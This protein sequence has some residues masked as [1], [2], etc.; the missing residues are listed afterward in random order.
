M[1][2]SG[3]VDTIVD[4]DP[5]LVFDQPLRT[6]STGTQSKIINPE[7]SGNQTASNVAELLD[8]SGLLFIKTSGP[9]GL[10]TTSIRGASASQ[11]LV[12]WNGLPIQSPMLGQ[13]DFS[14]LP[15]SFVDVISITPGGAASSWGSGAVAGAILLE[16]KVTSYNS[17]E[18]SYAVG[19][20]SQHEHHLK[21]NLGG[22]KL[23]SETR[24][25]FHSSE[26]DF[27]FQPFRRAPRIR[28]EHAHFKQKG[29]LQSFS[30]SMSSNQELDFHIWLQNAEREIPPL[31][32]QVRSLATQEDYFTRFALNYRKIGNQGQHHLKLAYFDETNAYSDPFINLISNNT[33]STF[34][35]DF[36]KQ[37]YLLEEF[38]LSAGTTY[39]RTKAQTA[40]YLDPKTD[41]QMAVF[42]NGFVPLGR[43]QLLASL[44]KQWAED[45]NVPLIPSLSLEYQWSEKILLKARIS[46]DY[47]L[48]T[49]NDRFWVPGGNPAIRPEHGWSEEIGLQLKSENDQVKWTGHLTFYNR[50]IDDWIIWTRM[51][52]QSF[53]SPRN[54]TRVWSRGIEPG[55]EF[56]FISPETMNFWGVDLNGHWQ[57][58]TNQRE[59]NNPD[60]EVGEQLIYVPEF[61]LSS[62]LFV[63]WK[64]IAV[65]YQHQITGG[66]RGINVR[67]PAY[68]VGYF[69]LSFPFRLF[70]QVSELALR[71]NNV[72]DR[73]YQVVEQ[74][75]MPGRNFKASILFEI[76]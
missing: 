40:A 67:L 12:L 66:Y 38:R 28:Q 23:R 7:K 73:Q 6:Q 71:V 34:L 51:E 68:Q 59:V 70:K 58:S 63:S 10:A 74:R 22:K 44:R 48:P 19:S 43:F 14:L 24:L 35:A 2:L 17:V 25:L 54:I 76:K 11:T 52:S 15:A 65:S 39:A 36:E 21:L 47:R 29:L 41:N 37:W 45:Q 33:F 13:L 49:L 16:N 4:I 42:I 30:Y 1:N 32:T 60:L 18:A 8:L 27:Y 5:V 46:H 20:F 3:Q 26:N 53:F 64:D 75:P 56:K 62:R 31:L 69:N 61:Q 9:G 72:W 55:V 57:K 50:L